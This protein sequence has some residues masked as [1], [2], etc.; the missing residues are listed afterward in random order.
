VSDVFISY[1]H[2]NEGFVE[3]LRAALNARERDVWI[4]T[5]GI[6]PADRWRLSALEAIER[7]D[8]FVFVLS[9]HSLASEACRGELEHAVSLN[10]R[11][12][13]ICVEESAKAVAKPEILDEL[14]WIMIRPEDDFEAG[15]DRLVH[16]LDTDLE[17]ARTHTRILVRANAWELAGR[18]AS[19]LLRGEELVDAEEWLS[20]AARDGGPQPTEL[21][22]A[23]ICASRHAATRRRQIGLGIASGVTLLA[24]VLSVIAVSQRDQAV[25]S[26]KTATSRR[27]AAEA[28]SALASEVSLSTLLALKA[29]SVRYTPQAELR[30]R[31]LGSPGARL[32]AGSGVQP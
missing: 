24:I 19:P 14:S 8:A 21:Q 30:R 1:A 13:A 22:R 28:E 20:R 6:E 16:A 29:L 7:S 10:K 5:E 18:R 4:D 32:S 27:L 9:R 17:V 26:Q 12:I 25:A 23:F 2:D 15:I 11:V 3:R 31:A